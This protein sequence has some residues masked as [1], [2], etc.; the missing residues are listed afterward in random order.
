MVRALRP[1]SPSSSK[2]GR[3]WLKST[4]LR[5]GPKRTFTSTFFEM[6]ATIRPVRAILTLHTRPK[7][8]VQ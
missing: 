1:I 4:I 3:Y 6:N 2:S 5:W 8:G 7:M